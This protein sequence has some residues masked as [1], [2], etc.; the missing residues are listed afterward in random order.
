M[1]QGYRSNFWHEPSYKSGRVLLKLLSVLLKLLS[2]LDGSL[3]PVLELSGLNMFLAMC[4][5]ELI[6]WKII[7][8]TYVY[9]Y[10]EAISAFSVSFLRAR[11]QVFNFWVLFIHISLAPRTF[12]CCMY[13]VLADRRAYGF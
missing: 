3:Y 7:A 12:T 4:V 5:F 11:S 13:P 2:G 1:T 10:D 9:V 6:E 8:F